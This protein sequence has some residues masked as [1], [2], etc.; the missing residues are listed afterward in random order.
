MP[1]NGKGLVGPIF[2]DQHWFRN[3]LRLTSGSASQYRPFHNI[4]QVA[5]LLVH[6]L[7]DSAMACWSAQ[8]TAVTELRMRKADCR[9][10]WLWRRDHF[11]PKADFRCQ[12][13]NGSFLWLIDICT[14]SPCKPTSPPLSQFASRSSASK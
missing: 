8:S 4:S 6:C 14:G 13:V 7:R 12:S 9:P 3:A 11:R 10:F 5:E 2:Y 1:T